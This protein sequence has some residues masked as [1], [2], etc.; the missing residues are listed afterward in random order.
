MKNPFEKENNNGLIAAIVIGSIA[1]AALAYLFFTED[2]EEVLA[3]LK[4][5]IKEKAKDIAFG[6]VSDKT[7]ISKKT[8]KNA[9]DV[10]IK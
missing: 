4:H 2:G 8:V 7:G 9:A 5:T 1:A 10:A 6:V 3:G